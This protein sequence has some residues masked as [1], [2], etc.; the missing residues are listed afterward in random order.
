MKLKS[1]INAI[2]Q[3]AFNQANIDQI[4]LGVSEAN[5]PEFGDYQFNGAM[6][7]SKKLRKNPREIAQM[8]IDNLGLDTLI[9]KAEIAGPGFINLWLNPL[10]LASACQEARENVRLG[11][12]KREN[13][14]KVVVDYSGPNM[15]K[16]MH[17]GHLRSTIIGDTLANLLDFLGDE[18]I[19]QNHIG[20]WGTQFGMLIAYLEEEQSD[21]NMA[22]KDLEVFYKNAKKRFDEDEN[23]ANKAREYVVKI[24]SGDTHCLALWQ[25]F[26]DISLGHCEEI[27]SKL[28][29]KLKREDVRSESFYNSDLPKVIEDLESQKMLKESKGAKCVFLEGNEIPVIVQKGDGGYLYASSDLSALRYRAKTLEADRIAYVVDARQAGHFKQVFSIAKDATFVGKEVELQHIGFGTM[30]DKSGK[31]FKTRDGG[32]VKLVDLLDEAVS[33][34]KESIRDKEDYNKEALENKARII[35]IG[36]VKYAALSMSRESNYI[37]HWDKM[38]SLEGNTSV[39]MLYAYARI[40]SIFRKYNGEMTGKIVIGDMLEQRLSVMLLRFED[41]L[42]RASIDASPHQ[43]TTYLYELATLFMRFYEQNPILKEE[44]AEEIKQSRLALADLT[45]K[46]IKKGLDILG[47]E[48]VDR[49]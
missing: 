9:S 22:L 42:D 33:R 34:A 41:V 35:G 23:F 24:Q 38:L 30:M 44:I 17:V 10:Y 18:V 32:T 46:T 12:L 28:N 21:G 5:K 27:Y 2:I 4:P 26:I 49:L 47:I 6:A 11:I 36:A 29:V 8:I 16:Q 25:K 14:M 43:I 40:Q 7:L 48:V 1:Q 19:R 15:A 39:Y 37:L 20:D 13:P 31:P 3:D 45:A